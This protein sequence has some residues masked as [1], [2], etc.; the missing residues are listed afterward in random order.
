MKI[1]TFRH[2]AATAALAGALITP[3]LAFAQGTCLPKPPSLVESGALT[4]GTDLSAPPMRFMKDDKPT[5]FDVDITVAIA[6]A[7]C[8]EPKF[9]NMSFQGLFPG[10]ISKKFDLLSSSVGITDVRMQTFDFVPVFVGGLRL[11]T[12]KGA[13]L[14]FNTEADVCGSSV[15]I[16]SGS[17]QM[18]ALE[19]VKGSCPAGKP[20]EMRVFAAMNE[21]VHEV[22]KGAAQAAF[23]DWPVAAYL[24]QTS[25]NIYFE[26]SPIL[27]GKAGANTLRNRNGLVFRKGDDANR[28]A[29]DAA[30]KSLVQSGAYAEILKKWNLDGGDVTKVTN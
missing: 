21:T 3:Q 15:A 20:M 29:V 19:R 23:I 4:I 6:K 16:V 2:L 9:V 18:A 28:A 17:T 11:I 1:S 22:A 14:F 7:M 13:N 5:G 27:S 24:V 8:L 26:A 25:P 12:K 10:L 30:F